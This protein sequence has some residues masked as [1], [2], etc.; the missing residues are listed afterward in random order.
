MIIGDHLTTEV[1]IKRLLPNG[2][3]DLEEYETLYTL[4]P[5]MIQ[6]YDDNFSEH[7]ENTFSKDFLMFTEKR[8]LRENDLVIADGLTYK[9]V[10]KDD[11]L[12]WRGRKTHVECRIR[13]S[14]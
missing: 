1:T 8:D 6:P 4:I 13:L 2:T 11:Y 14:I 3:G 10:S 9:V 7:L 12:Y 5:V